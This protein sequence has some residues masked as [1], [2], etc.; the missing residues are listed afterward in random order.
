MD[1]S[2]GSHCFPLLE[3][4]SMGRVFIFLWLY[5]PGC[6]RCSVEYSHIIPTVKLD[7]AKARIGLGLVTAEKNAVGFKNGCDSVY[8]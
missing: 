7:K 3:G 8:A 1:L 2:R 4:W 5:A 6:P